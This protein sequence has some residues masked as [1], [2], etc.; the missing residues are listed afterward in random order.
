M[1]RRRVAVAT[2]TCLVARFYL[3]ARLAAEC[4]AAVLASAVSHSEDA[5]A[6]RWHAFFRCLHP[7]FA[8]VYAAG[9][10]G[11][12]VRTTPCNGLWITLSALV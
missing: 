10:S 7:Y 3:S 4:A 2:G 5:A 8:Y 1:P 9:Y 11:A 6:V 12:H